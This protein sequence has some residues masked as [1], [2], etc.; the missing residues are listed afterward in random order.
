MSYPTP[1]LAPSPLDIGELFSGTFAVLKRRLGLFVLMA[2]FPGLVTFVGS[3]LLAVL[4]FTVVVDLIRTGRASG[5]V[6][7]I[8]ASLA[9]MVASWLVTYKMM[10]TM[11]LGA[12]EVAQG[13]HPDL[14]GLL[15][16][17]RGFLPRLIP[18][19]L[20]GILAAGLVAAVSFA[21]LASVV[22][23]IIRRQSESPT[24]VFGMV[25]LLLLLVPV[26]IAAL[27]YISVRMLYFVPVMANERLGAFQALTRSWQLTKGSF[28]RTFLN[29]VVG[30]LA[31]VALASIPNLIVQT[32]VAP[33]STRLDTEGDPNAVLASLPALLPLF[34]ILAVVSF[35]LQLL[36]V[37]AMAIYYTLM[38]VD[39]VRRSDLGHTTAPHPFAAPGYYPVQPPVPFTPNPPGYGQSAPSY[40]GPL[41]TGY[42]PTPPLPNPQAPTPWTAP[43]AQPP[44]GQAPSTPE[45]PTPT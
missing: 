11:S 22:P 24:A 1:L 18:V 3:G 19:M 35:A 28:W 36:S 42:Q 33:F 25:A 12:V 31:V 34:V 30:Q 2:V 13:Q 43:N 29:Y 37:P 7:L 20:I 32:V 4:A 26:L 8:L 41:N 14:R 21:V 45:P 44:T 15:T 10:A 5:L 6:P 16:R 23:T 40:G 38:Y 9:V 39:Q 27:V 17:T